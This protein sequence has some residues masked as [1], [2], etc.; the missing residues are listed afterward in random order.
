MSHME[1]FLKLHLVILEIMDVFL[2]E[3]T[4]QV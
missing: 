4:W 1:H 3:S 2:I